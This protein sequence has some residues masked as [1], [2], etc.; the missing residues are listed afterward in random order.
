MRLGTE[1][2]AADHLHRCRVKR[3]LTAQIHSIPR[4]DGLTVRTNRR[5][6]LITVDNRFYS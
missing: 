6:C 1:I 4:P 5:R 2:T 3:N